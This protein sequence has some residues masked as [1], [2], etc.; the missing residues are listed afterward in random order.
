MKVKENKK[1]I[2]LV[3]IAIFLILC[4]ANN[5]FA[6]TLPVIDNT[7]KGSIT[8]T[9]YQSINGDTNDTRV[10]AG[11]MFRISEVPSTI[12][13]IDEAEDYDLHHQYLDNRYFKTSDENGRIVVDNLVVGRYL[14]T[15][16]S[17]ANEHIY[18]KIDSFLVDIPTANVLGR[19]WDYD[20][21]IEPKITSIYVTA[22]LLTKN[23]NNEPIEGATYKL[24][25]CPVGTNP[26]DYEL[27]YDLVSDENGMLTITGLEHGKY[28]LVQLDTIDSYILPKNP[29]V[30][31]EIVL[32]ENG[33]DVDLE[34]LNENFLFSKYVIGKD[35]EKK[36]IVGTSIY[37]TTK[38]KVDIDLPSCIGDVLNLYM[39]EKTGRDIVANKNSIEVYGV[40]DGTKTLLTENTDY[41]VVSYDDEVYFRSEKIKGYESLEIYYETKFN[42]R[43]EL[44][45]G[46]DY[47]NNT[48]LKYTDNRG[49]PNHEYT[50]SAKGAKVHTGKILVKKTDGTNNLRGA[51]FKI[52][53]S[54]D[55][56]KSGIFLKDANNTDLEFTSD[57]QGNV[58]F[59]GLAYGV[60]NATAE[61]GS[62]Y[63]WIVEV[64]S[65]SYTEDG[66]TKYYS[67]LQNPVQ[68]LVNAT[69]DEYD[70]ETT[71]VVINRKISALPLPR[72]GAIGMLIFTLIGITFIIIAVILNKKEKKNVQNNKE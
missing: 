41:V 2:I 23:Q 52:A 7:V 60:D 59:T 10:L 19:G 50:T 26:K 18:E 17:T 34:M 37:E 24:Q 45:Y 16:I 72:T 15:Q 32:D 4:I 43:N 71:P 22:R 40:K 28:R 69:S 5:V 8:L 13:D 38:W 42:T 25:K 35:G 30:N 67:L 58:Y 27:D 6:T 29:N 12:D 47:T 63:Y 36:Q 51:V 20:V 54:E 3:A 9:V 39:E 57:S 53:T 68:V 1:I 55:N 21:E 11:Q 56:A 31:F 49:N 44:K 33:V 62:S 61:T 46:E 64:Q 14:I 66:E 70:E 48:V 65:P